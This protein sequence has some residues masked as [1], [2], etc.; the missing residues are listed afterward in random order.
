[1][2]TANA[3]IIA[4]FVVGFAVAEVVMVDETDSPR[5]VR[6]RAAVRVW[7]RPTG[8]AEDAQSIHR[9][10][11]LGDAQAQYNLGVM[12]EGGY[13]VP[14]NYGEAVKW[15]RLAAEQGYTSAQ[16]ALGDMYA[17]GRGVSQNNAKAREWYRRAESGERKH[18]AEVKEE[19]LNWAAKVLK[20]S[21]D[22]L[23]AGKGP[24]A[25]NLAMMFTR[26]KWG[27]TEKD[28]KKLQKARKILEAYGLFGERR[29]RGQEERATEEKHS[30][31]QTRKAK[32]PQPDT[33]LDWA[34]EV[35]GVSREDIEAGEGRKAYKRAMMSAHPDRPKGS[36]EEAKK[37]HEVK[38]ILE[39]HGLF[40]EAP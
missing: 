36:E 10:A 31:Q 22:D 33:D 24:E 9:R 26:S 16:K 4:A 27:G 35:L 39:K 32:I 29:S 18:R 21:R 20:I 6:E 17:H 8:D 28:V 30:D 11:V 23:D 12:C 40:A 37:L 3:I 13:G 34:A 7:R 1:M 38:T 5:P 2:R 25:Y 15:F 19:H 14:Q